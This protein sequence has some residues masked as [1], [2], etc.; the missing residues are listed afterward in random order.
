[1]LGKL[2]EVY[3]YFSFTDKESV[4][5]GN[6]WISHPDKVLF[7][8]WGKELTLREKRIACSEFLK[9]GYNIYL[10]DRLPLDRDIPDYRPHGCSSKEYPEDLPDLSL[11]LIFYNEGLSILMRALHSAMRNTPARLLKEIIL[12]DD[13]S[14]MPELQEELASRVEELTAVGVWDLMDGGGKA[15]IRLV[16]H[17]HRLGLSA[18]R[19]SGIRA[20]TSSVVVV[21]DGHVEFPVGW[22]EPILARIQEDRKVIVSTIFDQILFNNFEV[23]HFESQAQAFDNQLWGVYYPPPPDWVNSND[24]TAPI[25]SPA[26]M[27]CMAANKG[28]LEEIGFLD[29]GM[30]VYGGENVE[31]GIR[32]WQCGGRVEVLPC[33]RVAHIARYYKPYAPDLAIPMRRNALRLAEIWMDDYKWIVKMAWGLSATE[34][35]TGIDIGDIS[36]RVV[37]R[38]ALKCKSFEWYLDNVFPAFERHGNIARFGV[39][40]NSRRKDLCLDRGNPEKK[41]PIMFTCYGYQPQLAVMTTSEQ[42]MVGFRAGQRVQ[43]KIC[44]GVSEDGEKLALLDPMQA[45]L[46]AR[47][48]HFK[49]GHLRTENNSKCM[50]IIDNPQNVFGIELVLQRCTDQT[51]TL[52]LFHAP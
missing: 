22:A 4:C 44:L 7:S 42:I 32:A 34:N 25:R 27:G 23:I 14:D 24:P 18:S 21:M 28:Y 36:Q 13:K 8:N 31:L 11:V 47:Y 35:D 6:Q 9:Y 39:F 52:D 48:L 43:E 15:S 51:W 41:Q 20:A 40:T 12:V 50:E 5:A 38:K 1:M 17:A 29:E 30:L 3:L 49:D 33:S 10:S 2:M 46:Q 19:V 26:V 45:S 37:L 16:R